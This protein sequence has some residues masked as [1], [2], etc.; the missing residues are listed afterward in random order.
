MLIFDPERL[1]QWSGGKWHGNVPIDITGFCIDARKMESG[2]MFV[3]LKAERDGHDFLEQAVESGAS[4]ALVSKLI[5]NINLP[6]LVV[7]DTLRAFQSIA[8]N[9]RKEF[10][11][12]VVGITGSCGK[13]ST[14]EI[15]SLLL[16]DTA[17]KTARNLNNYLGVPLTLLEMENGKHNFSVVEVGINQ[18]DEMKTLSRLI[19]PRLVLVTMIGESHLEGLKDVA[20]V[21]SEKAK[22][23]ECSAKGTKALFHAD[24]LIYEN[25]EKWKDEN[26]PHVVVFEGAPEEKSLSESRAHYEIWTE[27]NK[28]G[29]SWMLRLWRHESPVLS[30]EIP[31]LSKGMQKNL[32]LAVLAA[33]ELGISPEL[34]S[35]RLPQ[36]RP[37]TL[38]AN[39]FQGRGRT[40]FIDCYNANPSSM[41][42]TLSFFFKKF[43]G[44]PKLYILGGMEE[45]GDKQVELHEEVGLS[46][47]VESNDLFVMIGEKAGWFAKGLLKGGA[48]EE[49]LVLLDNMEAA[50]S[51]VEDFQGSVLLK[52]SRS[53]RLE[54]LLPAWAVSEV[55][56]GNLVEC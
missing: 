55:V 14:K 47:R 32:V 15:L 10:T 22:L 30:L 36:Y 40:Y 54:N 29:D 51:L 38:R 56:D 35:E 4:A 39:R 23:F 46:I 31:E 3:A 5:L 12:P 17:H 16:G 26:H 50:R 11:I 7:D 37:S 20:T 28:I 8:A 21:A 18:V 34:I 33:S 13:T 43:K 6:Q 42:D 24:C 44:T 41:R 45:L 25:F 27:T 48:D 2:K 19:S 52:G 9:Y 49:Q 1:A 53:N